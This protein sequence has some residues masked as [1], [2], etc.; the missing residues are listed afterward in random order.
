MKVTFLKKTY[1]NSTTCFRIYHSYFALIFLK[2][3]KICNI[4][5]IYLLL[6]QF[7][8]TF[9]T[10]YHKFSGLE[11]HKFILLQFQSPVLSE[12]LYSFQKVQGKIHFV[13]FSIFW[14]PSAF[15]GSI[16]KSSN[17]AFYNFPL[18]LCAFIVISLTSILLPSISLTRTPMIILSPLK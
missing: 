3:N 6:Y 15:L 11:Q 17:V 14:R 4:S 8:I 13:A 18:G 16:F 1:C 10:N 5:Q 7:L 2:E 9:V 12:G